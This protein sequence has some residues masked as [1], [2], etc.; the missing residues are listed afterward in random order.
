MSDVLTADQVLDAAPD[1]IVVV[2]VDANVVRVNGQAEKLFLYDRAELLGKP[3]DVLVPDRARPRHQEMVASYFAEPTTRAMGSAI[4]LVGRRRDGSEVPV[5]VSLS[6]I[7]TSGGIL[8]C[9]AI[10][11]VTERKAIERA[12]KLNADRLM[13]AIESIEDAFAIYDADERLVLCNSSYRTI[14]AQD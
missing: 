1:A 4:Q 12:A 7:H 13:S 14:V 3:L 10:R 11:D 9:A 8:V 6:P 5:E 2:D